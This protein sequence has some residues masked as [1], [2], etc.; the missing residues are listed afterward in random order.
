VTATTDVFATSSGSVGAKVDVVGIL[1]GATLKGANKALL[2]KIRSLFMS[3][4]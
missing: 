4:D 1:K 3:I 2:S